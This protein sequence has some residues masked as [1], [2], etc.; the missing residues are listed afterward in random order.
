DRNRSHWS[1]SKTPS[2]TKSVSWQHHPLPDEPF[3]QMAF[4]SL[5]V[6]PALKLTSQGLFDGE[7]FAF[8]TLEV[9]E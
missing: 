1:T 9:T 8:T 5:P 6:I 2:Y 4:L 7:K 3:I